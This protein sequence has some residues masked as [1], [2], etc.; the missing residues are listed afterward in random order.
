MKILEEKIKPL[1]EEIAKYKKAET[2]SKDKEL[3]SK[4]LKDSKLTEEQAIGLETDMVGKTEE[5]K[6]KLIENRIELLKKVAPAQKITN[7]SEKD[8][9]GGLKP[10]TETEKAVIKNIGI[11]EEMFRRGRGEKIP[12]KKKEE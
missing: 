11:S 1:E 7:L 12:E 6:K 8:P 3:T 9:D 4:L 2:E 10:L 5:E